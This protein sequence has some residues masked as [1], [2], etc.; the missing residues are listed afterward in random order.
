MFYFLLYPLRELIPAFRIFGYTSFRLVMAALTSLVLVLWLGPKFFNFLRRI[1]FK[2]NIREDGPSTH[3]KKAGTPTM[4]GLLLISASSLSILLWGNLAN[5]HVLIFWLCTFLFSMLGFYDDYSKAKKN[6][7]GGLAPKSKFLFQ[8]GIAAIFSGFLFFFPTGEDGCLHT[9]LYFPFLKEPI[10]YLGWLAIPFWILFITAFSNAVNLTD[11]L[12]GL[13][14]GLSIISLSALSAIG[15]ITGYLTL[16][17]YLLIPYI[18]E[19]SEITVVVV[20][21]IGAC[22]GFLWYNGYPAQVFMGDTGS[23]MLGGVISMAAIFLKREILLVILGGV[24]VAETISVMLQ[25]ASYKI[26]KKRIFKM[27]PLHHH[28]ELQGWHENKIVSRFMII[29]VLLA[30]ISMSSLKIM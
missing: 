1:N 25:V 9:A 7:Q 10:A 29:G 5:I 2:E 13:A 26:R 23:L 4:G 15:F 14:T 28:F 11:G 19:S 8:L 6:V 20:A 27:A 17:E 30:L 12:D 24:F 21:V 18:P 22:I 3:H 16:T